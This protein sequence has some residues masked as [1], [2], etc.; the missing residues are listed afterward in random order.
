M[1]YRK[2]TITIVSTG[3]IDKESANDLIMAF[4]GEAGYESFDD[5]SSIIEGY[6]QESLFYQEAIDNALVE[7]ADMGIVIE[8]STEDAEDKNWN[9]EWEQAGFEPMWIGND[10]V[11]HDTIH[12]PDLS[13]L[14][15]ENSSSLLDVTIEP[16]QAFGSGTHETTQ[17]I[18]ANLL[19]L[20]LEGKSVLDCGCGT[21]ILG[22]VAA[23]RGAQRVFCY[24]IDSWSVENTLHNAALNGVEVEAMEGDASVLNNVRETF[25][26]VLA[27]INR[28]IL[29]ADLPA[30]AEK[31]SSDGLLI[32]SGFYAED[33]PLLQKKAA[34]LSL[35]TVEVR[36]NG[37]WN[38][39]V[40]KK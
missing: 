8:L 11:I 27:N 15:S 17:M 14:T 13:S 23:L 9:E 4:L 18:V 16:R 25:D 10:C 32:L 24:D 36:S 30:F 3:K 2:T 38:M 1:K 5:S 28:N 35:E 33:V 12:Y 22:I 39:I 6:I 19:S 21:G 29:L 7:L 31:M 26:V 40:L 20:P 34:S 37:D